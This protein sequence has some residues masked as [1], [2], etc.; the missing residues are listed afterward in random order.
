VCLL[1]WPCAGREED[2]GRVLAAEH[3]ISG[4]VGVPRS[5]SCGLLSECGSVGS[6][7]HSPLQSSCSIAAMFCL[8]NDLLLDDNTVALTC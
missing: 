2:S 6:C 8:A 7:L 3:F 1:T 4:S 5:G